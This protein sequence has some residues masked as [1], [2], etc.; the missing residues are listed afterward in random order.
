VKEDVEGKLD[1]LFEDAGEQLLKNIATPV[2]V[3]QVERS[4]ALTLIHTRVTTKNRSN[5]QASLLSTSEGDT[6]LTRGWEL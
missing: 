1:V 6:R 4:T 2:R 3:Y 5:I